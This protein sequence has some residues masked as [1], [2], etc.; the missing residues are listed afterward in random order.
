MVVGELGGF[1]NGI[2]PRSL[3]LGHWGAHTMQMTS[4]KT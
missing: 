1:S 4:T 2:Q 3:S